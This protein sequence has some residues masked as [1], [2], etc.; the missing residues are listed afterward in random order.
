MSAIGPKRTS[1]SAL[2]MSAFGGKADMTFRGADVHYLTQS[3][4]HALSSKRRAAPNSELAMARHVL[5]DDV[6]ARARRRRRAAD[7][8]RWRLRRRRGLELYRLEAGMHELDLCIKYGGLQEHQL[9][10]KAAVAAS[11]GRLLRRA[12]LSLLREDARRR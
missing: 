11:L 7:T 4:H 2:H 6:K 1:A 9:S 12:L 3:G 5:P 10:D 8:R